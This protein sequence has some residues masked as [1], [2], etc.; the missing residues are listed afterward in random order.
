MWLVRNSPSMS[1]LAK[2]C[3][4][5]CWCFQYVSII[6][7]WWQVTSPQIAIEWMAWCHLKM[8]RAPTTDSTSFNLM[9]VCHDS[10]YC[11]R[12]IWWWYMCPKNQGNCPIYNSYPMLSIPWLPRTIATLISGSGTVVGSKV[13][14]QSK[15]ITV[16]WQVGIQVETRPT[17]RRVD[18]MRVLGKK[19]HW[20][21]FFAWKYGGN[22]LIDSQISW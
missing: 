3:I 11:F 1:F 5:I 15:T 8:D 18:S 21:V 22:I 9:S 4:C 17:R 12:K 20:I 10:C 19:T 13:S 6:N 2:Q 14:S 16:P 7:Y